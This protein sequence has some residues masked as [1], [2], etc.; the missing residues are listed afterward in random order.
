MK[1]VLLVLDSLRRGYIEHHYP[2]AFIYRDHW[3]LH[4]YTGPSF[5]NMLLSTTKTDYPTR[6]QDKGQ[7]LGWAR[8][9][10]PDAKS[11]CKEFKDSCFITQHPIFSRQEGY[12]RVAD[13]YIYMA[14]AYEDRKK[15]LEDYRLAALAAAG[16]QFLDTADDD[17]MLLLWS[18]ETHSRGC[19]VYFPDAE[20]P[21][22]SSVE[23]CVEVVKPL[24]DASDLF[25]ITSDHGDLIGG[26]HPVDSTREGQPSQF[27]VPL[28]IIGV[29]RGVHLEETDHLDLAPL[30]LNLND[31]SIPGHYEGKK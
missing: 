11:V 27:K 3:A 18:N 6:L 21:L 28:I 8:S 9:Y 24:V 31:K 4:G 5:L 29:G 10:P 12:D 17:A 26:Q 15:L 13:S 23:Y 30:I 16:G 25:I 1:T 22:K 2:D 19:N 14:L 7:P 20:D